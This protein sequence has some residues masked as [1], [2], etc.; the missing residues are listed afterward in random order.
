MRD[1]KK[2]FKLLELIIANSNECKYLI[3]R[4][5]IAFRM[6]VRDRK[7]ETSYYLMTL[8][9]NY[10]RGYKINHINSEGKSI[11][12]FMDLFIPTYI[13]GKKAPIPKTQKVLI[14]KSS[15]KDWKQFF[16]DFKSGSESLEWDEERVDYYVKKYNIVPN[17]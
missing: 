4:N 15:F 2:L 1:K 11:N 17:G 10:I 7:L 9:G 8:K 14:A 12:T 13:S 5:K 3:G 6:E 16:M